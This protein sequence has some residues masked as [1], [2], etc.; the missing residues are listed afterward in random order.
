MRDE[1]AVDIGKLRNPLF[2]VGFSAYEYLLGLKR[3]LT[4]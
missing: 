1:G 2:E 4:P 3:M